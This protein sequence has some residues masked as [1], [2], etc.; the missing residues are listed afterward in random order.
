MH[1]RRGKTD[2][3]EET[4]DIKAGKDPE[5]VSP[6]EDGGNEML[7]TCWLPHIAEL[8]KARLIAWPKDFESNSLLG[9]SLAT[10]ERHFFIRKKL[11]FITSQLV[12]AETT[13]GMRKPA[14]AKKVKAQSMRKIIVKYLSENA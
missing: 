12:N 5:G 4:N 7:Q 8:V 11:F 9:V 1:L 6:P 2:E 13:R 14:A 3:V 10:L